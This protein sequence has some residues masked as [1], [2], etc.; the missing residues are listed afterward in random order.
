MSTYTVSRLVPDVGVSVHIAHNYLLCGP[1]RPVAYAPGG[2]DL[3][4]KAVLQRLCFVRSAFE[5]DVSL[6]MLARLLRTLDVAG[7]G[8]A[9][10]QPVVLHQFVER[11]RGALV[12]LEA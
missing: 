11:R 8:E 10:M 7:G 1:S 5:A 12:G 2:C 3:F 6:D 4:D 9:A